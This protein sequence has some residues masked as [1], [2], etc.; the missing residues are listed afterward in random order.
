MRDRKDF[1][2]DAFGKLWQ[3]D[4]C[5]LPHILEDGRHRRVYCIMIIDDHSSIDTAPFD[6]YRAS[7][8]QVCRSVSSQWLDECFFN[9]VRRKVNKDSTAPIDK[10]SYDIP[11]QF[12]SM[13]VEIRF[14]PDDMST[15]YILYDGAHYP[16]R[17]TDRNENYRTKRDN[18]P[19][20]DYAKLGGEG[21]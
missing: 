21:K 18:P 20:I 2:E 1:K 6:C 15:A 13:K 4:A 16:I 11:M 10:V 9:C 14:L 8:A 3:A 5:Y 19:Y 7:C 17:K 12:I